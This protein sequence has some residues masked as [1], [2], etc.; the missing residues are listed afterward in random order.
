MKQLN[1]I[2]AKGQKKGRELIKDYHNVK[3]KEIQKSSGLIP[4]NDIHF[5]YFSVPLWN[6]STSITAKHC[7][8]QQDWQE[9]CPYLGH[10]VENTRKFENPDKTNPEAS[11]HFLV[12]LP[13]FWETPLI[14]AI[15]FKSGGDKKAKFTL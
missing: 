12:V 3:A 11:T 14:S 9:Q 7:Q 8:S 1:F 2:L 6:A 13:G 15:F 4:G 10:F 5:A